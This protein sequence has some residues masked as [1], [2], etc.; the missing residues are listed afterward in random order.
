MIHLVTEKEH[1]YVIV[2][3]EGGQNAEKDFYF[4]LLS[5]KSWRQLV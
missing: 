1:L 3:C 4:N 5:F 2:R